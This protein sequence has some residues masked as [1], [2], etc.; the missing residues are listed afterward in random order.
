MTRYPINFNLAILAR[1]RAEMQGR[2]FYNC[3][4]A[5]GNEEIGPIPGVRVF[6]KVELLF[7]MKSTLIVTN[8]KAKKLFFD[9]FASATLIG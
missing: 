2:S 4:S 5:L 8:G 7:I 1:G 9:F 3:E 6:D